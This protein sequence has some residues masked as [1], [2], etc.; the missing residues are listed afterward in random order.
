MP[1]IIRKPIGFLRISFRRPMWPLACYPPTPYSTPPS[2]G[3]YLPTAGISQLF[4]IPKSSSD[5]REVSTLGSCL[6]HFTSLHMTWP[7]S[8]MDGLGDLWVWDTSNIDL[9]FILFQIYFCCDASLSDWI[10]CWPHTGAGAFWD[11]GLWSKQC[12][13]SSIVS[14]STLLFC[15]HFF[16]CHHSAFSS[17]LSALVETLNPHTQYSP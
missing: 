10:L 16:K 7:M 11:L 8:L 17:C 4:H 6:G 12:H 2:T 14:S 9:I 3:M 1:K 13:V 15:H 5:W